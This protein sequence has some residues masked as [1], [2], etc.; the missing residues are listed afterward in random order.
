M[1]WRSRV[2]KI[3]PSSVQEPEREKGRRVGGGDGAETKRAERDEKSRAEELKGMSMGMGI[4]M[5]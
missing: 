4:G 3:F 2:S 5:G 1:P